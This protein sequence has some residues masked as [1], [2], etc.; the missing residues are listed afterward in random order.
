MTDD[1]FA[2][3]DHSRCSSVFDRDGIAGEVIYSLPA[4]DCDWPQHQDAVDEHG[5]C[6]VCQ[7]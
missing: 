6:P 4:A 7:H 2:V 1:E 3:H 5:W